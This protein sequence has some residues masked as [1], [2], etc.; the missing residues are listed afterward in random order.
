MKRIL[1]FL[2]P[3]IIVCIAAATIVEKYLGTEFVGQH[4]YGAWWFSAFWAVMTVVG[5]AYMVQQQLYKRLAVMLLHAAFVVI[6][7]GALVTHLTARRDTIHLRIDVPSELA[8]GTILTLKSFRIVNY[9][10]TDAPLDYQSVIDCLPGCLT[11]HSLIILAVQYTAGFPSGVPDDPG[12][13]HQSFHPQVFLCSF[14]LHIR[15]LQR[16]GIL[17]ENSR[18]FLRRHIAKLF[19]QRLDIQALQ[20]GRRIIDLLDPDDLHP[21]VLRTFFCQIA[22]MTG[23]SHGFIDTR[24]IRAHLSDRDQGILCLVLFQR[25]ERSGGKCVCPVLH[26]LPAVSHDQGSDPF[27]ECTQKDHPPAPVRKLEQDA[28]AFCALC[29]ITVLIGGS[30]E[31]FINFRQFQ[32]YEKYG[33]TFDKINQLE[34]LGLMRTEYVRPISA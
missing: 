21:R 22:D 8:S 23:R 6:L 9:P 15:S 19:I 30:G 12:S 4:I 33:V 16:I 29:N 14:R 31:P 13:R 18:K 25:I 7:V 10:G 17:L 26:I 2:Y 28:E 20:G 27:L 3:L 11:D 32:K 34:A 1:F 24:K 5:C